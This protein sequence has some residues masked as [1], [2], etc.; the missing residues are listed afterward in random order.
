LPH[1]KESSNPAWG[2]TTGDLYFNDTAYLGLAEGVD[3]IESDVGLLG[4]A[5][6]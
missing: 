6:P 3:W 4:A 2:E 1:E 5:G